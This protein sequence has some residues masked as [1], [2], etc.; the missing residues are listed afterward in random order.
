[1]KAL[2]DTVWNSDALYYADWAIAD[3]TI[4]PTNIGGFQNVDPMSSAIILALYTDGRLPDSMVGSYGFTTADQFQW[5]GNLF[6]IEPDEGPF[7]SLL[8]TLER[9]PLSDLTGRQA[10]HF[11]ADALQILVKNHWCTGFNITYELVKSESRITLTIIPLG[12][13][14]ERAYFADLFPLQ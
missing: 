8:W 4:E 5:H 10:V 6:G 12:L 3:P 13:S 14:E 2:W 11:A 1:M 9:A 7:N